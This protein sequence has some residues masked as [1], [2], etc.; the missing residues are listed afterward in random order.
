MITY[1]AA[2]AFLNYHEAPRPSD[3][4]VLFIG[5]DY[6]ERKK[7]ARQLMEEGYAAR[8]LIPALNQTGFKL[9][10]GFDRSQYPDYYENTH[11]EALEAKKMMDAAG[12]TS[13]L[14]VSSP[15]HMRRIS[16]ISKAVFQ[17]KKYQLTFRGSRYVK[18][19]GL[20]S[21]FHWSEIQNVF[22]EYFKIVG[23]LVY[24]AYERVVT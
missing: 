23:F 14:F 24:Q 19:G 11:I 3:A 20:L 9:P 15:Y 5:P 8:L 18:T 21:L 12:Y 22:E 17:D 7:E 10:D 13:A 2:A 6:P 16:M 1:T 4:V